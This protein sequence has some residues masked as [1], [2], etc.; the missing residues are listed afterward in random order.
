MTNRQI[1]RK[2]HSFGLSLFYKQI[3]NSLTILRLLGTPVIIW[4]IAKEQFTAAFWIFFAVSVT[5]WL[6]GY[7]ARRW[8]V[9]S[10]FG[11]L[12]DPL[13]DK[14][15]LI[16]LYLV[17]GLWGFI[18]L[19]LTIIVFTRDFLILTIGGSMIIARKGNI[20]L[21]PQLS[22][23]ISTTLQMLF[24]GLILA[25]GLKITSIPTSSIQSILMVTFLYVVALTTILSGITYAKV[26]FKALT[27]R[28]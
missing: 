8:E 7:L 22:G 26:V 9:T 28:S 25:G 15:L 21:P 18:P 10:R 27:S 19:W 2:E 14:I 20:Q 13:A 23:K 4:L 11:Q 1:S 12:L 3:P 24:I 5:D 16:S 6:D 17:L